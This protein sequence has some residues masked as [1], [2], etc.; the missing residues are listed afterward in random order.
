[1]TTDP[2][3]REILER[4]RR[5]E[6]RL[7]QLLIASGIDAQ[8]QRPVFDAKRARL[9]VPSPHS[10]LK[11]MLDNI[12]DG[13]QDRAIAVFCGNKHVTTVIPGDV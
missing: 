2:H 1:M 3:T 10:S 9:T 11:E 6:T 7:T 8:Q 4:A 13:W 5:I 12:P